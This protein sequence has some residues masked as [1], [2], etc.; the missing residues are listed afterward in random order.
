MKFHQTKTFLQN[1]RKHKKHEKWAYLV[2]CEDGKEQP[3]SLS[4]T[5]IERN[6]VIEEA[7]LDAQ[8]QSSRYVVVFERNTKTHGQSSLLTLN[9]RLPAEDM[10]RVRTDHSLF[11]EH[12]SA[13]VCRIEKKEV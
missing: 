4:K 13:S 7:T 9:V 3:L 5:G 10:H 1:K 6:E 11:E 12:L 8:M 2:T